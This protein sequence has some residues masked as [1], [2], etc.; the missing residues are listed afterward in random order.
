[1]D[2]SVV[3]SLLGSDPSSF[4]SSVVGIVGGVECS[5]DSSVNSVVAFVTVVTT[6][7]CACRD[8]IR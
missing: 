1:M 3:S 2:D 4:G 7:S 5:L 6:G 8:N